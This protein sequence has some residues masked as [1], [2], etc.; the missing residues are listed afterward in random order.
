MKETQAR[1]DEVFKKISKTKFTKKKRK[2][3]KK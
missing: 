1:M 3:R 2:A